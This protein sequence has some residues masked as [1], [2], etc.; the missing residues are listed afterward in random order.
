MAIRSIKAADEY[1][2]AK[3][4]AA[5]E[6]VGAKS[7]VWEKFYEGMEKDFQLAWN[8]VLNRERALLTDWRYWWSVK[9]TLG[10]HLAQVQ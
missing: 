7:H 10:G 5:V 6:L 8:T 4:A 2:K 9:R 1:Q 3:W